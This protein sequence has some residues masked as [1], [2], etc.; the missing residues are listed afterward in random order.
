MSDYNHLDED[1]YQLINQY[2]DIEY[3]EFIHADCKRR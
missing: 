2:P 1:L 3:P